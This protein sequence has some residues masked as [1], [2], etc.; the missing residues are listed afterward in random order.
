MKENQCKLFQVG[1]VTKILNITRK[2][3]LVY[4]KNGLLTPAYKNEE[5]GY[6]YYSADN[7]TQI[8]FI[9]SMQE[10]GLTLKEISE[11]SKEA[12]SIEKILERLIELKE[13]LDKNIKLLRLRGAKR[14]DLTVHRTRLPATVCFCQEA[15]CENISDATNK[16]RETYVAAAKTGKIS[17]FSRMFTC[18]TVDSLDKL[19]ILCCIPVEDSFSGPERKEFPST[20]A[21]SIYYRGPYEGLTNAM[22]EL[23]RFAK[24]N[25][26]DPAGAPRSI[27]LEGPPNRKNKD[28]YIT[29]VSLPI[30]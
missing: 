26:L 23:L 4:E 20:D 6:R 16:L 15:L 10:V 7:I 2:T 5:S 22:R 19:K 18:R 11:Y 27:F 24:E 17:K 30:K 8:R 14:G 29:E 21:I 3:L 13:A 1:E 28:D 12:D 25:S 9:R